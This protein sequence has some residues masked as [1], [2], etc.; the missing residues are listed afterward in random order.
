MST[1]AQILVRNGLETVYLYQH[2]N[3][4][5]LK[6]KLRKALARAGGQ[7]RDFAYLCRIIFCEMIRGDENALD[8]TMDY[9]IDS[10]PAKVTYGTWIVD[11]N[12]QMI[13]FRLRGEYLKEVCNFDDFAVGKE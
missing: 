1:S 11:V 7:K 9:G 3:G 10:R 5:N 6:A 4:T 2:H 8:G 12:A 13:S